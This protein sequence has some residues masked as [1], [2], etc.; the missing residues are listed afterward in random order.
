MRRRAMAVRWSVRIAYA[1][2]V[3][4]SLVATG[5][6]AQTTPACAGLE[7]AIASARE[8]IARCAA[9]VDRE[10][11]CASNQPNCRAEF[12]ARCDRDARQ[13]LE[14]ASAA[15]NACR[16]A[17]AENQSNG[18]STLRAVN[19]PSSLPST[20]SSDYRDCPAAAAKF[21]QVSTE[22]GRLSVGLVGSADRLI[23]ETGSGDAAERALVDAIS[24]A[25]AA[26]R[27]GGGPETRDRLLV[28]E[29]ALELLRCRP[30][31]PPGSGRSTHDAVGRFTDETR[32]AI[33]QRDALRVDLA[34]ERDRAEQQLADRVARQWNP[35]PS[36]AI[37]RDAAA[38]VGLDD[39]FAAHAG[40]RGDP[41][42]AGVSGPVGEYLQAAVDVWKAIDIDGRGAEP[43]ATAVEALRMLDTASRGTLPTTVDWVERLG[44]FVARQGA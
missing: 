20:M 35:A 6:G 25:R 17:T 13:R 27:A 10:V 1:L 26:V 18:P 36:Y 9:P 32:A 11:K 40:D 16:A 29:G 12:Q 21:A 28:S 23:A 31:A 34:P 33:D 39:P 37:D 3:S 14:T 44:E 30:G 22:T 38:T 7:D 8:D 2:S 43:F 15:W 19:P 5:E 42:L 24:N 4:V 41:D